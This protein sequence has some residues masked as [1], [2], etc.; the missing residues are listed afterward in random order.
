MKR[1]KKIMSVVLALCCAI[2][3]TLSV[4]MNVSA[5]S[6]EDLYTEIKDNLESINTSKL[7]YDKNTG[8]FYIR[9]IK[10]QNTTDHGILYNIWLYELNDKGIAKETNRLTYDT[11]LGKGTY[12]NGKNTFNYYINF[13][14]CSIDEFYKQYTSFDDKYTEIDAEQGMTELD[15]KD[16]YSSNTSIITTTSST[17]YSYVSNITLDIDTSQKLLPKVILNKKD[18]LK[19]TWSSSDNKVASVD[20]DG[21]VTAKNSGSCTVSAKLEGLDES[22]AEYTIKVNSDDETLSK[23]YE[24][25][26]STTT[27]NSSQYQ[28]LDIDNDNKKE[29]LIAEPDNIKNTKVYLYKLVNKEFKLIQSE[30]YETGASGKVACIYKDNEFILDVLWTNGGKFDLFSTVT[31]LYKYQNKSLTMYCTMNKVDLMHSGLTVTDED[32]ERYKR[33]YNNTD[34]PRSWKIDEK[35]VSQQVYEDKEKELSSF[36]V[37]FLPIK[38]APL[39]F[40]FYDSNA[41]ILTQDEIQKLNKKD[42]EYA[43]N[44]IY[45]RHGYIFKNEELSNYF[46]NK[47]WYSG[48]VEDMNSIQLN[49]YE[50]ENLKLLT[51]YRQ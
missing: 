30:E 37:D 9:A 5:L 10:H 49:S 51:K 18:N 44:E 38:T 32:L 28:I 40:V 34:D 21:N 50:D 47:S 14:D 16:T 11:Y 48:Y 17:D 4:S 26:K 8:K 33:I 13:N 41:R 22:I 35:E 1:L 45:A 6:D 42:I 43:I 24:F 19:I 20:N 29:I 46:N 39:D 3:M 27:N 7:Y 25:A 36:K 2:T 15:I 23:A 12:V 31:S